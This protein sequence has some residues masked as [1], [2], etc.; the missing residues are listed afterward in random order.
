MP[1]IDFAFITDPV[2]FRVY[3]E[4]RIW[5]CIILCNYDIGLSLCDV[6]DNL[7][8]L[9][10]FIPYLFLD[11]LFTPVL[12][13]MQGDAHFVHH[14]AHIAYIYIDHHIVLSLSPSKDLNNGYYCFNIYVMYLLLVMI[15]LINFLKECLKII[16]WLYAVPL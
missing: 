1:W 7:V 14:S 16:I 11:N 12:T 10:L 3:S 5:K 8:L 4:C 15:Y 6:C 9:T 2:S 13:Y